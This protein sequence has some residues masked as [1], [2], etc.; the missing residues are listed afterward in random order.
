MLEVHDRGYWKATPEEL[1]KLK[2]IILDI[3]TWLE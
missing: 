3:E 2:T 1:E